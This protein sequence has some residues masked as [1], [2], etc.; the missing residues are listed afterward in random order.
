MKLRRFKIDK[1]CIRGLTAAIKDR[2]EIG[3]IRKVLR[4]RVGDEVIL[5]DGE[6][7]EYHAALTT[8]SPREISLTLLRERSGGTAEPSLR[9]IL[10][11]GLLKSSKFDWLIQKATELGVSEVVPFH[12]L[13]A[14]PRWEE[15]PPLAG[16]R[17]SRWEKIASEAARQCGRARVPKIHS[18][19]PF[20]E[21]LAMKI[22]DATKI[23]LWEGERTGSLK[24][25]LT[26]RV[27][28]I[29]ALVGPEGGFSE[30]EARRA[31][32]AGF[33]PV[34]LGPRVLRAETAGIA[35][36]SLLQFV[37]GDLN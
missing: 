3:H 24:N 33:Q 30:E 9:I 26:S 35:I 23:L 34:G 13:H 19:R 17:Q 36:V 1:E 8:L 22:V 4:L 15:A 6:G 18:P 14:V 32:E 37:L 27:S 29:Y 16:S 5:F 20:E 7:R 10:G 11:Q 12:S 21:M 2:G 25:A 31:Q 28:T